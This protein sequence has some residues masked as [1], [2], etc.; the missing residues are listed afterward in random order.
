[1]SLPDGNRR[2]W[3]LWWFVGCQ[4]DTEWRCAN[5]QCIPSTKYCDGNVDCSDGTDEVYCP[6]QGLFLFIVYMSLAV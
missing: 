4:A 6:I 1:M 3:S 5:S 2:I